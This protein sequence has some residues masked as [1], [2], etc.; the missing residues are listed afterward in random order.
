MTDG[1]IVSTLPDGSGIT[2]GMLAALLAKRKRGEPTGRITAIVQ[3]DVVGQGDRTVKAGIKEFLN[4]GIVRIEPIR[5]PAD[6]DDLAWQMTRA[7]ERRTSPNPSQGELPLQARTKEEMCK[8]IREELAEWASENGVD[9]DELDRRFVDMLGG[10][11]HAAS[12]RVAD[13]S[14]LH[15]KEFSDW[16]MADAP[17]QTSLTVAPVAFSEEEAPAETGDRKGSTMIDLTDAGD[18]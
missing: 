8:E 13:A 1:R 11:E 3:F 12:E 18:E 17:K 9:E 5:D 10:P 7:Y 4:L 16:I 2:S 14:F 6:A 15:L